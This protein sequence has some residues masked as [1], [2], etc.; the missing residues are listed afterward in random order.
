MRIVFPSAEF[1]DAVAAVCHG[2]VSEGQARALNELLRNNAAA[3]DQYIIRLE[4]HSCLGSE[5]DL[6]ALGETQKEVERDKVIYRPFS[7]AAG[8]SKRTVWPLAVA[9]VLT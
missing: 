7:V 5:R 3:L 6:F 8:R 9:A 4:L 2:T 1:D